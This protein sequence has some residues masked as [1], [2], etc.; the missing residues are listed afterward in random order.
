[1]T[2]F[3]MRA[4]RRAFAGRNVTEVSHRIQNEGLPLLPAE[5]RAAVP[6]LQLV[7]ERSTGKH[8]ADRFDTAAQMADAL[9]Q[10]LSSLSDDAT[11]VQAIV[12]SSDKYPPTVRVGTSSRPPVPAEPP[13]RPPAPPESSS[14]PAASPE[15]SSRPP[16]L[17]EPSSP[18]LASPEISS[19][20]PGPP[21]TSSRP[22]G[23]PIDP[24]LLRAVEDKLKAYVGPI[25]PVLVRTAANRSR[26][27]EELSAALGQSVS[28]AER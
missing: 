23:F 28:E 17:P 16:A 27:P 20:P 3:E 24:A 7:L 2:L 21:E 13:S 1:T 5:L 9:R 12:P 15:I 8:P 26:S 25:A 10:L 19:P 18:P 6:R 14:P 11:R 22:P 4:G